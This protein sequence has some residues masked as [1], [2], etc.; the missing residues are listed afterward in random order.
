MG[1]AA[2]ATNRRVTLVDSQADDFPSGGEAIIA[3]NAAKHGQADQIATRRWLLDQL[4]MRVGMACVTCE[5]RAP[6]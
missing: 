3:V 6:L 5:G 2:P 4:G 1:L